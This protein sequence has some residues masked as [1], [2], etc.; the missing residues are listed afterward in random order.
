ML[1][2][3]AVTIRCGRQAPCACQACLG[4]INQGIADIGLALLVTEVALPGTLGQ[5]HH[6]RTV[7]HNIPNQESAQNPWG[8]SMTGGSVARAR[9]RLKERTGL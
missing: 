5:V 6:P 2:V 9:Q 8:M 3:F 1:V 7:R 4:S